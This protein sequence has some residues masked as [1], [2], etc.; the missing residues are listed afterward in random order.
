MQP[1]RGDQF[2]V[3]KRAVFAFQIDKYKSIANRIDL[4]MVPGNSQ[5]F[6]DNIIIRFTPDFQRA[7][8][9]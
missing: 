7:S 8:C 1:M 2:F 3:D 9:G 5:V 4:G 6:D